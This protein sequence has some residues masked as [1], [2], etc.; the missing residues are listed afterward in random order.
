MKILDLFKTN[1]YIFCSYQVKKDIKGS[2][3]YINKRYFWKKI[4]Y[5][6]IFTDINSFLEQEFNTNNINFTQFHKL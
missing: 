4:N 6:N 5:L 3:I 2:I 1:D